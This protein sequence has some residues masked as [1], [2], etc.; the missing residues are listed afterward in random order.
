MSRT[1]RTEIMPP[2]MVS[3]YSKTVE[4]RHCDFPGCGVLIKQE[5]WANEPGKPTAHEIVVGLDEEECVSFRHRRDYCPGH[6]TI[7]WRTICGAIAAAEN[8]ERSGW[9]E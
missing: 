5:W 9:D 2:K 7:V 3:G 4:D 6:M 1:E 8:D